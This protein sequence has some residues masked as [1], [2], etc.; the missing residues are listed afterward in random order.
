MVFRPQFLC[1]LEW[2]IPKGQK[3]IFAPV[4]GGY[5]MEVFI[6]GISY[7][8]SVFNGKEALCVCSYEYMCICARVCINV[9]ICMCIYVHT[10]IHT[11]IHIHSKQNAA[12]SSAYQSHQIHV[13]LQHLHCPHTQV[14]HVFQ[15]CCAWLAANECVTWGCS[16]SVPGPPQPPNPWGWKRLLCLKNGATQ[17]RKLSSWW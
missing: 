5:F 6:F 14:W 2:R 17:V 8:E 11:Y 13:M 16:L 7:R 12:F 1:L 15:S 10:D 9:Y 3:M 4:L